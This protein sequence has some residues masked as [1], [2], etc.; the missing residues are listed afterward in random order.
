MHSK[1]SH[2][3][4]ERLEKERL[5]TKIYGTTFYIVLLSVWQKKLGTNL[6]RSSCKKLSFRIRHEKNICLRDVSVL[7]GIGFKVVFL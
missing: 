7:Q 4:N 3:T 5:E 2:Q 1:S 6:G